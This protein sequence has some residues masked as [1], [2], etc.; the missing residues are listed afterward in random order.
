V[1]KQT[2]INPT[3]PQNVV[4]VIAPARLHLGFIDMHGG[5]GRSFGSLGLCL[6]DIN[7]H[8]TAVVSDSVFI[9]GP[10]S[11]RASIYTGRMLEHLGIT[12]GVEISILDAIPEH[13]GLGSGTQLSLAVG[14]AIAQIY[15]FDITAEQLAEI[16]ERGARSGIGIGAFT[17][18]GFLVDGGRGKQTGTPPIICHLPFPEAWRLVLVLDTERQGMHGIEEKQAFDSL[19]PMSEHM[20]GH[21]CR[22]TL[23]QALPALV[24]ADC[25]QFGA[26]ISEI[27]M[28]VGD[29]FAPL[30]GG[31][32]CNQGVAQALA[33]LKDMGATGIGQ[34]SWGPTGFALFANETQAYQALRQVRD[35]WLHD[36]RMSF[37]VSRA[38]NQKA[39]VRLE[40]ADTGKNFKLKNF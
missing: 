13:A 3:T 17:R 21:L 32:Y 38:R 2:T 8:I 14:T 37:R 7:T 4:H 40:Q 39:E 30:Q 24:E 12:T 11:Q 34:S 29:H 10:S 22:L 28:L 23:M 9:Q 6:A 1:K 27:Q 26:T 20:S 33:R 35:Q 18:G 16:M 36:P 19:Q 15:G 25:E 31:R 5:M